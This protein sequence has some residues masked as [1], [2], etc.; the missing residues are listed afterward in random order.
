MEDEIKK[1]APKHRLKQKDLVMKIFSLFEEEYEKTEVEA[2]WDNKIPINKIRAFLKESAHVSYQSNQ[3]V[4]T[5]LKRYENELG[6]KLFRRESSASEGGGFS[7]SIHNQMTRFYQKQHLY[8]TKK[9]KVVNGVFD[10]INNDIT[11]R[12]LNRPVK[13]LLGAGS[14]IYHLATIIADRSW[15]DNRKYSIYTH[16]LGALKKLL[17]PTVNYRNIEVF[18]PTG[19]IDPVT[20]TILSKCNDLYKSTDFDFIIMGASYIVNGNLFEESDDERDLKGSI[21]KECKGKKILVL[22]KQEFTDHLSRELVSYGSLKDFNHI[23]VPHLTMH[24]GVKKKYDL[25]FEEY[26]G[27]L[28]PQIIH[29]NYIIYKILS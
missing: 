14:T 8:V 19:R 25:L 27:I 21:L 4:Y 24:G 18:T 9:I 15:Q 5:Q 16:N 12:R 23:I 26:K 7:L 22:T 20:Y 11:E 6:V 13:I 17:E 10:K 1:S 29:W 2:I 3:W 28:S